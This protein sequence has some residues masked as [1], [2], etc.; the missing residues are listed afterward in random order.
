MA[1]VRA[2]STSL[3]PVR[4]KPPSV[5]KSRYE[6]LEQ[7]IS[8]AGVKAREVAS[9]RENQLIGIGTGVALGLL[10]K[11]GKQLPTVAGLDPNLLYGAALFALAPEVVKGKNGERLAAIGTGMLTVAGFQVPQRGVKVGE[12]ED[13][14]DD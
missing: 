12:L 2:K 9:K 6:A 14:D 4:S 10:A 13:D 8:R 11:S 1:A 7:R 3:V 5:S